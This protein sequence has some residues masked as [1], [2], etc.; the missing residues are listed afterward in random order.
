M[1]NEQN[2]VLQVFETY[3][4]AVH[5]KDVDAFLAIYD[6]RVH[7]FDSWAQW[8]HTGAGA[9]REMVSE[10]FGGLGDERVEVQFNDVHAV[11]GEDIAFAHA[12]VTF[13]GFSAEGERS[14]AMTNRFTACL[15]RKDGM[16]KIV[17]EHTSLP[18]DL[19]TGKGIFSR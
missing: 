12:A 7:V 14:R 1:T 9:R 11:V 2:R 8:E 16:W 3:R 18:I 13:A 10:W 4:D 5:A 15:E 17:H 6:E 19:E